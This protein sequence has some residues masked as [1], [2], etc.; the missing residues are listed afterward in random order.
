MIYFQQMP[1]T[2]IVDLGMW[3]WTVSADQL[4]V[5]WTLIT[6]PLSSACFVNIYIFRWYNAFSSSCCNV[7]LKMCS[8][9]GK[10]NHR[11]HNHCR[12]IPSASFVN[13]DLFR[14]NCVARKT[15]H[16]CLKMCSV[17]IEN[18]TVAK[19]IYAT[20]YKAGILTTCPMQ[21]VSDLVEN[22]NSSL[23]QC[24]NH[25]CSKELEQFWGPG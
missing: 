1:E 17:G 3:N 15:C 20:C 25:L 18:I 6:R 13:V 16:V 5:S 21:L 7:Y 11:R 10:M 2:S 23:L 9:G 19:S 8:V 22:V 24:H 4:T 14:Q 12:S